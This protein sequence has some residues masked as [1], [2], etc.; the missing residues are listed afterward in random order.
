M[1]PLRILHVTPY[2]G[3]AWAYGGIPRLAATLARDLARR[4]HAVTV[5]TTDACDATSR[6]RP[7]SIAAVPPPGGAWPSSRTADGVALR[8]FPNLSNHLAYHWQLF[9]PRGLAGFMRR[10]AREFDVAHLHACRNLPVEIAARHL[11]RAGVPFVLAPNGTAPRIERRR[12]AKR[13]FD[14]LAGRRALQNAARVVAVSQ[15]EQA[16]LR[17]LGVADETIALVPNPIDLEEFA[18]PIQRGR[19]RIRCSL[20]AGPIVLFLGKLTPRKRVDLLVEAFARLERPD[21]TLVIAGNDMGSGREI[22]AA[23]RSRGIE[24]AVRFTGLLRGHERLE[25]L[26]DADVV[27]YPSEHEVFGL[28]PLEALLAGTSVIVAG[29]SGSGEVIRT[30]GGGQV[31]PAGDASA[32]TA[33]INLVIQSPDHWRVQAERAALRVRELYGNEAVCDQIVDQYHAILSGVRPQ[34]WNSPRIVPQ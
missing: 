31:V 20:R 2:S 7:P 1:P 28:V 32:L 9:L 33:A 18:S 34:R 8:V 4:G 30:T 24:G 19:L 23:I 21:A 10:H 25:A 11:G 12:L 29:D 22:T 5:A 26:A 13:T 17:A 6:L 16:Q 3:D 14:A 15:A 27:V